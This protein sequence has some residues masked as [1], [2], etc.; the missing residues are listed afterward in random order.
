MRRLVLLSQCSFF[1]VLAIDRLTVNGFHTQVGFEGLVV[2]RRIA[3]LNNCAKNSIDII[4]SLTLA[5]PVPQTW[6]GLL[7]LTLDYM[8]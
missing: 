1:L 8:L 3:F 6:C 7:R 4:L 2:W 5:E